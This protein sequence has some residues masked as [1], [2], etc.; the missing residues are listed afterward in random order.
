MIVR[1]FKTIGII[2]RHSGPRVAEA[3]DAL[4]HHLRRKQIEVLIDDSTA[5]ILRTREFAV[6]PPSMLNTG[7]LSCIF[8]ANPILKAKEKSRM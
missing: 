5:S 8:V 6:V 1:N 2:G 3:V 7:V 4:S